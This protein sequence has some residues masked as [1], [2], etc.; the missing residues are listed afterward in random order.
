MGFPGRNTGVG[1]QFLLQ[2]DVGSPEIE[3][4]SPASAGGLFTVE[5]AGTAHMALTLPLNTAFS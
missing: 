2:G 1:C 4:A 5:A 3:A